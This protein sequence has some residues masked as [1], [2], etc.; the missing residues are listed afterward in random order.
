MVSSIE[1]KDE[2][3]EFTVAFSS[4]EPYNRWGEDEILSHDKGAVDLSRLNN[5]APLLFN[6]DPDKV[7]GVVESARIDPDKKGRAVI[8]FSNSSFAQECKK[9]VEDGILSK[10][11]VGYSV[12]NTEQLNKETYLVTDWKPF[13]ISIVSIPADDTVGFGRNA[14]QAN[15][16][17]KEKST[18]TIT[19]EQQ[20]G[21]KVELAETPNGAPSQKLE[22]VREIMR[23]SHEFNASQALMKKVSEQDM[24][25][26]AFT[27]EL[28]RE[29]SKNSKPIKLS[30]EE[31]GVSEE[32]TRKFS[33][34]SIW[35]CEMNPHDPVFKKEAEDSF[36]ICRE[37]AKKHNFQG[38]GNY[39]PHALLVGRGQEIG[40]AANGGNLVQTHTAGFIDKLR[41]KLIA[42][43]LG[44]DI[45]KDLVGNVTL[46]EH[47]TDPTIDMIAEKAGATK[48]QAT[49]GKISL[50]MKSASGV[51]PIT[52]EMLTQDEVELENRVI[53]AL[54]HS[55]A[56][57]IN[58][59]LVDGS[60]TGENALGILKTT[61]IGSHTLATS[62]KPTREEILKIKE[63]LKDKHVDEDRIKLLF[64]NSM[65]SYLE[66]EKVDAGSGLFLAD[67]INKKVAMFP[68]VASSL[69][70]ANQ[71]LAGDFSYATIGLW[72]GLDITPIRDSSTNGGVN[73]EAYQ[74]FD[75]AV[76]K[77]D[78][79]LLA[80]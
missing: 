18:M 79:F 17:Q 41:A 60:G 6:H 68:Y 28:L 75:I 54:T 61:G 2:N 23:I 51:V 13:E 52:R 67:N 9:D 49:F 3:E 20:K 46:I 16:K 14:N 1:K 64:S 19:T 70:P 57:K 12:K 27:E 65:E 22:E 34:A 58:K 37:Y 25:L 62:G 76:T 7:I 66:N 10:I 11:S 8:K 5:K 43:K 32:A 15:T 69:C 44:V 74:H 77:K 38:I 80:K 35:R 59:Q 73:V 39:V 29:K 30:E 78:A 53:E 45:F 36:Q 31:G 40:T 26:K 24:S 63:K 56:L 4:E 48:S 72:G 50:T 47:L 33:L 71:I 42:D 21:L 55:M